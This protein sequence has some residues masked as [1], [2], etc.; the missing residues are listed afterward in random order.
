[1]FGPWRPALKPRLLRV[2]TADNQ[3]SRIYF[4][5]KD[6]DEGRAFIKYLGVR[7]AETVP[8]VYQSEDEKD[9]QHQYP[10][11]LIPAQ[12]KPTGFLQCYYTQC[13]L[14]DVSEITCCVDRG[15]ERRPIIGI[16]LRYGGGRRAC[17]GQYRPG[18]ADAPLQVR[19]ESALWVGKRHPEQPPTKPYIAEVRLEAPSCPGSLRWMEIPWRGR[20]EW[21]F[22][23]TC[24]LR[25]YE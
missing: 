13:R 9:Y 7:A 4:D 8:S 12:G 22:Y 5:E 11:T 2:L 21:W 16:L 25:H 10:D 15:S 19:Q 18:W 23:T 20:L 3:P 24:E 6:P 17:L 1:M 14:E